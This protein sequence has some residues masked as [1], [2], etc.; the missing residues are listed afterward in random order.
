MSRIRL[1]IDRLSLHGVDPHDAKALV[2]TLRTQ[3][4]AVLSDASVRGQ[5]ARSHRIPVLRL[6]RIPLAPGTAGAKT[7]GKEMARAVGR[8]LNS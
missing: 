8:G 6:G 4:S 1:T 7:F 5:W 3:L 2:E